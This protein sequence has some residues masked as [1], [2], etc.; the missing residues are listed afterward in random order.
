MKHSSMK[1]SRPENYYQLSEAQKA[2]WEQ[3]LVL[4]QEQLELFETAARQQGLIW[5]P[6]D[7]FE[8]PVRTSGTVVYAFG[9]SVTLPPASEFQQ[10]LDQE[11]GEAKTVYVWLETPTTWAYAG[12]LTVFKSQP[13]SEV[14]QLAVA[15]FGGGPSQR[16]LIE[17]KSFEEASQIYQLLIKYSEG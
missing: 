7:V 3:Y 6:V 8:G 15:R 1:Y 2:L 4:E 16:L 9:R 12:L 10:H 14:E 11:K 13:H 5:P 17:A